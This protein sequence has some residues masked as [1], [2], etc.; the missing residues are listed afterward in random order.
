MGEHTIQ[1]AANSIHNRDYPEMKGGISGRSISFPWT[2]RRDMK[3]GFIGG[4]MRQVFCAENLTEMGF[5]AA[6][7]GFDKYSSSVGLCTRCNS[8]EDA[9]CMADILILPLPVT[10]DGINV[11]TPLS[12]KSISLEYV[13]EHALGCSLILYGGECEALERFAREK[14]IE[15]INYYEREDYKVANA[16]PTAEGAVSIAVDEMPGTIYGADCLILGYGR[17]GKVLGRLLHAFG[18]KVCVAARK[19]EDL[20]WANINGL[21]SVNINSMESELEK[22]DLIVNTVPKTILKD[23]LLGKI[24]KDALV[25]DLASKPGGIDFKSAKERGLNV[26]WALSLPGKVAPLSAGKILSDTVT[27]ILSEKGVI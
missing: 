3:I 13:F 24:R 16:V 22:S 9:A 15:A 17:I 21:K 18:G 23:D 26:V 12:E 1:R 14:G 10:S 25:L 27:K 2:M 20:L 7:F 4:D 5:E 6:L 11:N 8:L 19:N